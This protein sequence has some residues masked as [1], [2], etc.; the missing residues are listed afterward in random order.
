MAR[1]GRIVLLTNLPKSYTLGHPLVSYRVVESCTYGAL[2]RGTPI[3][4]LGCGSPVVSRAFVPVCLAIATEL[5]R[6]IPL[7]EG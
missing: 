4:G 3:A 7:V 2:W 5:Q 1:G 6:S